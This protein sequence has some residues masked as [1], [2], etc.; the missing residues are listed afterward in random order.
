MRRSTERI[1]ATHVGSLPRPADLAETILARDDGTLDSDAMHRL[2]ATIRAAV[3]DVVR[4]QTDAGLDVV[5]DGEMSKSGYV[6]YV[7]QRLSG[8]EDVEVPEGG[9]LSIADLDDYPGMA[10]TSLAGLPTAVPTCTGAVTYIGHADLRTD[11]DNF[12]AALGEETGVEPFMNAASPGVISVYLPNAHYDTDDAY[13][14]ALAEAMREEYQAITDAGFIL[15]IDA[16]DLAM[17]RHIKYTHLD[18]AAFQQ[19]A[20]VHVDAIN[21]AVRDIDPDRVRVHLCYGNYQGP[22]HRDIELH[23]IIDTVLR[24]RPNGLAFESANH[25][26]S[27]EWKVLHDVQLPEDKVIIPGLIDTSSNYVEHPELVAERITRYASVVGRE[28]ILAGTDC[29]FASFATFLAVSPQLAWA[30]L[31]SLVQGTELATAALWGTAVKV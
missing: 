25:R 4:T 11:L 16:P 9:G 20:A 22:H 8:F 19:R 21:H 10:E 18:V 30:K 14:F 29:G 23:N 26:H 12:R 13:L 27:H 6:T 24:L 2:P 28:R 17:G 15:Q 7:N 1:L 5:S 3:A 31:S